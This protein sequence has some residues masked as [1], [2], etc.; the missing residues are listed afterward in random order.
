LIAAALAVFRFASRRALKLSSYLS[1]TFSRAY[2]QK[3]RE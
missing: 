2:S 1:G 3:R